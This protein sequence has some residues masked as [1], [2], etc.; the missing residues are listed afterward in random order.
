METWLLM[1]LC[2]LGPLSKVVHSK[3]LRNGATGRPILVGAQS[4]AG[5]GRFVQQQCCQGDADLGV[6]EGRLLVT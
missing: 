5:H 3:R 4:V 1:E 2:E 6:I